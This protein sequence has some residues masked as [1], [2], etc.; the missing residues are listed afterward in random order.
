MVTA[1]EKWRVQSVVVECRY[2]LFE[3]MQGGDSYSIIQCIWM[4]DQY[5]KQWES[6][7]ARHKS[8]L[9]HM[10]AVC[11]GHN[12]LWSSETYG[13][14]EAKSS[15]K[16]LQKA[17]GANLLFLAIDIS[18][19]F[20]NFIFQYNMLAQCTHKAYLQ[21]KCRQK[22]RGQRCGIDIIPVQSYIHRCTVHRYKDIS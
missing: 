5:N 18:R 1:L 14:R 10:N 17:L 15:S 6:I 13:S 19:D 7:H 20:K 4:H 11:T 2:R 22:Y 16:G 3:D 12:F 8:Q 9:K 21:V